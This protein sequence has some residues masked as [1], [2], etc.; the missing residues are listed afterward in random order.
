M[1][2]STQPNQKWIKNLVTLHFLKKESNATTTVKADGNNDE[3]LIG[4]TK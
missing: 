3:I 2:M 4:K 1:R